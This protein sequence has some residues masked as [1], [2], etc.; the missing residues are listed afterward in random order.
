MP[1]TYSPADLTNRVADPIFDSIKGEYWS[2]VKLQRRRSDHCRSDAFFPWKSDEAPWFENLRWIRLGLSSPLTKSEGG[3]RT[4]LAI[5]F[6]FFSLS[7]FLFSPI[8]FLAYF[9]SF[10]IFW[11]GNYFVQKQEMTSQCEVKHVWT[12]A[13][14]AVPVGLDGHCEVCVCV[15]KVH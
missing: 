13:R 1:Y 5:F 12:R 15:C 4:E 9:L 7:R 8:S 6:F 2:R 11:N 3:S 14:A 10:S